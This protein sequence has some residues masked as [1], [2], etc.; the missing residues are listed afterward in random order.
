MGPKKKAAKGKDDEEDTS[1]RDLL[2]MYRKNC[3]ELEVPSCKIF[4][5]KVNEVLEED[6]HL[7]EILIN[8]KVGELGMR[9]LANAL[10]K[11]K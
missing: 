11:T 1:T 6:A 5:S 8:E 9:S 2:Y 10:M 7:P 3:K 4:E